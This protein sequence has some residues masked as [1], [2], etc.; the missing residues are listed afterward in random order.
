M[1][2]A[3]L[4]W[5]KLFEDTKKLQK[6]YS[7]KGE[8]WESDDHRHGSGTRDDDDDWGGGVLNWR[9]HGHANAGFV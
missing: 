7:W 4:G 9:S 1:D 2:S 8:G 5:W 3:W 6:S